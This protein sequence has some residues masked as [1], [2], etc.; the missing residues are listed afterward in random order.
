MA[1]F[2]EY[3]NLDLSKIIRPNGAVGNLKLLIFFKVLMA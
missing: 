3:P 2:R 1:I